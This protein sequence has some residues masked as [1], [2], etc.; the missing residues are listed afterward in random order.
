M[1]IR[2][3][4]HHF[5]NDDS[6]LKI[7]GIQS[8]VHTLASLLTE[9]GFEV[10][11]YEYS[12]G[13]HKEVPYKG[14][15]VHKLKARTPKEIIR[16]IEAHDHDFDADV[17]L[18]VTDYLICKNRFKHSIAI[19]HGVAWDITKD[20]IVSDAQNY[21]A[22]IKSAF[23][24][25]KKYN[26]YKLCSNL[27]CVDYNF[28]NWYRT[29]VLHVNENLFIVPSFTKALPVIP[30][31]RHKGISIV[32]ARR[33]FPY[34][35]TRL[36]TEAIMNVLNKYPEVDVTIAGSG[37]DEQWMKDRLNDNKR[38]TFTTFAFADSLR[39]HSKFDIAVIPTK[40]SEGTSLSLLE[41]M[42]AGCAVIATNVGGITNIVLDGYNGLLIS[43]EKREL[44]KSIYSLI[45]NPSLRQKLSRHG[46][47]TVKNSFSYEKWG[48]AWLRI[49]DEIICEK[50]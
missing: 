22:I 8:Y 12:I 17:L 7:G 34:R 30:E 27:V 9:H 43:P 50:E 29:Q 33:L 38:V 4:I 5:L 16:Y 11:I 41:A 37:P 25:I 6:S 45:E 21:F 35:G 40:G 23:R 20:A 47:E 39:F 48:K 32:F 28:V 36:F 44:E 19:Q 14:Y 31:R 13:G 18:F 2:I 26:R 24:S 1:K 3:I 10:L 42:A 49:I 15:I 46:F